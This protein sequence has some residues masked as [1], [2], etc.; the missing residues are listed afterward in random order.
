MTTHLG[1]EYKM[2]DKRYWLVLTDKGF[3]PAITEGNFELINGH[4][5]KEISE[6]EYWEWA[7]KVR[8]TAHITMM[9]EE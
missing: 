6:E 8:R 2:A 5:W 1:N 3:L 4:E 9:G 7:V